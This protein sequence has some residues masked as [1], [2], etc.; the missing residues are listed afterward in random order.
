MKVRKLWL[1]WTVI[2]YIVP[3]V[4]LVA[5]AI[6]GSLVG[7]TKNSSGVVASILGVLLVVGLLIPFFYIQYR[8]AYKNPGTKLL[9]FILILG[10]V[11][12]ASRLLAITDVLQTR[13]M[14]YNLIGVI[15]F[16]CGVVHLVL[17]YY[18]RKNNLLLIEGE[19]KTCSTY[20]NF[21]AN[22]EQ[23]TT[24]DE[25]DTLYRE[26]STK[27]PS[28]FSGSLKKAYKAKQKQLI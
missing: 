4:L 27:V 5:I 1:I 26:V 19:L 2:V 12:V 20:T 25:I 11:G 7:D 3:V 23:A 22:L 15:P 10:S 24:S 18:M 9:L 28:Y 8:C 16:L 21:V 14:P 17:T 13:P 6:I